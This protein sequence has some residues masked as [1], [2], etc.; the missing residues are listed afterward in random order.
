MKSRNRMLYRDLWHLRGQIIAAAVVVSCGVAAFVSMRS[1]YESLLS[2]QVD[3]YT[4]FRFADVFAQVK[5]AP[6]SLVARVGEIPGVAQVR[7]RVVM[8]VTLDVPRLDEPAT[9]RLV[10]IPERPRPIIND[11][12]LRN[13]RYLE[14][15]RDN[16]VIVSEAFAAANHLNVGD[17]I[18]AVINGRWKRLRVVGT[19]LSPEYIYEVGGGTIFP[20]NRRFGVLWMGEEALAAAFNMDGAFND[21]ALT[22]SAGASQSDVIERLDLLLARYGGLGAYGREEQISHR[23]ISDEI[24]QNRISS[25]YIPAIFLGVATF[26]LHIVLSRLVAMQRTEIGLL[27]AFGYGN[28]TVGLHYLKLAA[29]TVLAGVA[30][31]AGI[32]VYLGAQLTDLYRDY[33]RFPRLTHRASPEVLGLTLVIS[34]SAAVLGALAAVRRA[35]ALPPAVA[36]RPEPPASFHAGLLERLGLSRFLPSSGRIIARSITRRGWKSVIAVLGIACAAGML[37]LGGFFYDA[38]R[39]LMWVQFEVVQRDDVTVVFTEPKSAGVRYELARLPGV[40]HSEPFRAVQARLRFEHRS[41][42]VELT[43]LTPDNDLRRLI[44]SNL[45]PVELPQKGL[46]LTTKLA[47]LLGVAP[48]DRVTVEVLEHTRAVRQIIISGVVEEQVGIAAYM[49]LAALN[50][51]LDE[52]GSVSGAHLAVD[53]NQAARLYTRL[54]AIPAV[55]GV[56]IREAVLNSFREIL[57]RSIVVSTFINVLFACVIAF[58]VVYNSARIALSERGNE[59]ASL[60]VLGFTS[61]EVATILLGEQGVLTLIAIPL[62]FALGAATCWLLVKRLSTELYR[63]PLVLSAETFVFAAGI[64]ALAAFGSGFLV[65]R[66]LRRLDLIS[67]LKTRE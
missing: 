56:A 22:L 62:G 3:Y 65:A 63:I 18:G 10:S 19:A 49:N 57:D 47:E 48:G 1:T 55:S 24:S 20:D 67:V 7:T 16:E 11:L 52:Q 25:T 36:T 6:E 46:L 38:I 21:L 43:G 17:S 37:V 53:A 29:I 31:G 44:D 26:L 23:F 41:R 39:Y 58:G 54:K 50:R 45:R 34:F 28:R 30:V 60:R 64:V 61:N 4:S 66:R 15:G 8:Q 33:Y 42:R 51:L 35:A 9:G 40:L 32:G 5:R 12:F 59:L 27:K 2:A 13:G 14:P